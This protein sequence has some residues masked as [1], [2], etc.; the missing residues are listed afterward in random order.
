MVAGLEIRSKNGL[1]LKEIVLN[2]W[3]EL[4]L[5]LDCPPFPEGKWVGPYMISDRMVSL[6]LVDLQKQGHKQ[7]HSGQVNWHCK[8][9][10]NE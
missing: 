6:Y 7:Y 3:L 9:L 10:I 2:I 8:H 5:W 1:M 4:R